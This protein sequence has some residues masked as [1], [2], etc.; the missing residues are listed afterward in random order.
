MDLRQKQ[1]LFAREYPAV[2]EYLYRFIYVRVFDRDEAN[3]VVSEIFTKA[4]TLLDRFE[5]DRGNLRQWLTG[6]AKY[7]LLTY[8]R[9][10]KPT[11]SLELDD[12]LVDPQTGTPFVEKLDDHLLAEKM[13]ERLS[14]DQKRLLT[15]RYVDGLTYEELADVTGKEPAA[16]RQLFSR[17]HRVLRLEFQDAHD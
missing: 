9:R 4:Y 3:D 8:W 6:F 17:L 1:A 10:K 15:L 2:F 12:A 14:K 11:V 7:E 16:L 13:Y 5:P